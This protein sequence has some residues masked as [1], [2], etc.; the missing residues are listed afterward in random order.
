VY[1]KGMRF[2]VFIILFCGFCTFAANAK[3]YSGYGEYH[4]GP[5]VAES[6]ACELAFE[7]AKTN[8]LSKVFGEKINSRNFLRCSESDNVEC[9]LNQYT[10]ITSDG[11]I[12]KIKKRK[13]AVT[14]QE[15]SSICRCQIIASIDKPK[16]QSDPNFHFNAR[17]NKRYFR[18]L[19]KFTIQIE[20]SIKMFVNIF[21]WN[22]YT[23]K[24]TQISRIFP[25]KYEQD[26]KIENKRIIPGEEKKYKFKAEYPDEVQ[27]KKYID[28][29]LIV[30]ATKK[31][32]TFLKDYKFKN[33]Q[34]IIYEIPN[35]KKRK[36]T[37]IYD[38][39]KN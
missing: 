17:I 26:N 7:R 13:Q 36:E 24:G 35:N 20:P 4:F 5:N 6:R 27:D 10:L 11:T 25:N 32:I 30:L 18:N 16:H 9:E 22:P 21:S 39:L 19:E 33:F 23:S 1:A 12:N 3:D 38:V 15:G 14:K 8:A 31:N 28:Q 37:I 29:Y 2:L 34:A